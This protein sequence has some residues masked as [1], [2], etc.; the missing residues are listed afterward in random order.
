MAY[1]G[2]VVEAAILAAS[3]PV[4]SGQRYI[5]T[6]G[7]AYSSRELYE[8]ICKALTKNIPRWHVPLT[9]LRALA[10]IGD[11][12]GQARGK[13]APFDSDALAKVMGSDWYSC[14][15]ISTE[16]GYCPSMTFENALPEMLEWCRGSRV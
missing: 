2:D 8:A 14:T 12:I 1:V 10:R 15:K 16:L 9:A 7:R 13:R 5:V 3:V 11:A 6:D 4:A